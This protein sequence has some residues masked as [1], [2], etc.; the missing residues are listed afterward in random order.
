[1]LYS[2]PTR[3]GCA[4]RNAMS[5]APRVRYSRRPLRAR[6]RVRDTRAG[7]YERGLETKAGDVRLRVK[8]IPEQEDLRQ[9]RGVWQPS[10]R[11][12]QPYVYLDGIVPKR[13][14]AGERPATQ[15]RKIASRRRWAPVQ[16]RYSWATFRL[17]CQRRFGRLFSSQVDP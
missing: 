1:M 12:D 2:M 5:A 6:R 8:D 15:V 16:R 13:S 4:L 11:G 7:P 14:W 3:I 10:D 17:P 9:D